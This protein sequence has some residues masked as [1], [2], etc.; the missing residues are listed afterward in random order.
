MNEKPFTDTSNNL[1]PLLLSFLPCPPR[2]SHLV[3]DST[4]ISIRAIDGPVRLAV[5]AVLASR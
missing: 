3:T 1:L 5:V 4:S 2:R